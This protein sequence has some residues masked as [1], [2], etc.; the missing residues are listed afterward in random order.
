MSKIY[1]E[2]I[3]CPNCNKK[4]DFTCYGSINATSDPDL[5]QALLNRELTNFVCQKCH[6]E[7][8][9]SYDLLY[10]DMQ[11]KIFIWL[12]YPDEIGQISIDRRTDPMFEL[13]HDYQFRI[14]TSINDLIEKILIFDEGYDDLAIEVVKVLASFSDK[15]DLSHELLFQKTEKLLLRDKSLVFVEIG[16]D[17]KTHSYSLGNHYTKAKEFAD[18]LRPR[19]IEKT[20]QWLLYSRDII[21]R[22]M[23][24]A[25]WLRKAH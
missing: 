21:F 3:T 1:K 12:K 23:E 15:I 20:D 5:K 18:R 7:T 8:H 17:V 14:V 22:E 25:G 4:Q 9:V 13:A 19:F 24:S 16:D 2:T 10:H 6:N 11:K